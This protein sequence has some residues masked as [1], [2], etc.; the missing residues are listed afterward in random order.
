LAFFQKTKR[1]NKIWLF[2]A[3][4]EVFGFVSKIKKGQRKSFV[5]SGFFSEQ[6]LHEFAR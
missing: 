6:I 5:F 1:P 3:L 2:V 4:I